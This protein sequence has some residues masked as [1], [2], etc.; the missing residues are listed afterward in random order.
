MANPH[1][2][3]PPQAPKR[4]A[5]QM[6]NVISRIEQVIRELR[7]F[8]P[9]TVRD[10]SDPRIES[11]EVSIKQVLTQAFPDE[12]ERR[13]TLM[14]AR[15]AIGFGNPYRFNSSS[16]NISILNSAND[17]CRKCWSSLASCWAVLVKSCTAF[18]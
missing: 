4:T 17:A 5:A 13:L 11:L 7:D 9:T 2:P 12:A 6:R 18:S 8:D 10:R 1:S 16:S 15:S 3:P 14:S